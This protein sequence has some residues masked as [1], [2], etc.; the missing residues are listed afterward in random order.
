MNVSV[1]IVNY[2]TFQMTLNCI[3]SVFEKTTDIEF[4][5][6]LIDNASS[7]G[8]KIYFEKDKRIKYVYSYENMGFGRANNVG[9]MLAKGEYILLLN[10]DT[11]LIN[12]AIKEF[13]DYAEAHDKHYFYGCWLR[14]KDGQLM[15]SYG[16]LPSIRT[17]LLGAGLAYLCHIP[18]IKHSKVVESLNDN[19]NIR[20][21]ECKNVGYVTGA[22]MFFHRDVVEKT[23]WFDHSF[24]MYY[25]EC[26]WQKRAHL[27]GV[28]SVVINKPQ[29]THLQDYGKKPTLRGEL[30]RIKSKKYY[31]KKH[32]NFYSYIAFRISY[33]I[34]RFLPVLFESNYKFAERLII[35][36]NLIF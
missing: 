6:I 8:S 34:L 26:D 25:E 4:E 35:L 28:K 30:M 9:I 33:L 22:D 31:Y 17:E 13:Y 15:H 16:R 10:S 3:N 19:E 32:Y 2:N 36:K 29:V 1:I 14:N 11:L 12:N 18:F 5:V 20:E 7:D 27:H 23:G 24:F 21:E